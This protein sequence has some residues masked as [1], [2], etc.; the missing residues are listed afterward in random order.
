[1]T[2]RSTILWI[3]QI[4]SWL[5]SLTFPKTHTH[6]RTHLQTHTYKHTLLILH[7][8]FCDHLAH[9]SHIRFFT[10]FS[11]FYFWFLPISL[12]PWHTRAHIS[13]HTLVQITKIPPFL[14]RQ[15]FMWQGWAVSGSKKTFL[16]T[17]LLFLL[18]DL[19]RLECWKPYERNVAIKTHTTY[20]N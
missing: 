4:W 12:T 18:K 14:A 8:C 11:L 16:L 1:M 9:Q 7:F 20:R 2:L 10:Y 17:N 15:T 6:I 13:R 19:V 5:C 3:W